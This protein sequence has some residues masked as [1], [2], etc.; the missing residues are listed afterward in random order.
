LSGMPKLIALVFALSMLS[1]GAAQGQDESLAERYQLGAGDVISIRVFGEED[2]SIE[3]IR[4]SDAATVAF[5]LLGEVTALGRTPLELE[6][7]IRDRLSGDYLIN[8]RVT[9]NVLEY[10]Q[11]YVNGAVSSPGGYAFEPGMTVRRAIALAGGTTDRASRRNMHVISEDDPEGEE[12]QV[13]MDDPLD[14]GDILT[15]EESF[16]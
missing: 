4:L 2:L 13:S 3:R 6:A 8:P 11:F 5:P 15:I 10:R 12:R 7:V 14:P 16:F 9:V 1:I